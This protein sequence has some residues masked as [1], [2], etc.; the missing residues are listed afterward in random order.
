MIRFAN[1]GSD[2]EHI[3]E[4]FKK[5]Y[6]Q[7]SDFSSFNLDNMADVMTSAK[8]ASSKGY[9]GEEALK[10]SY[11]IKDTSRNPLYNQ[12]KMYAEVYRMFGWMNSVDSALEF[13]FTI[14]GAHVALSGQ[15][16][17]SIVELCLF[18]IYFPNQIIDVRFTN[19]GK[20]YVS[21][22]KYFNALDD[23]LHRDE[24]IIGALNLENSDDKQEFTESVEQIKKL[25]SDTNSKKAIVNKMNELSENLGI[26]CTTM[27]NYTRI[28]IA[29][30]KYTGWAEEV[31]LNVYGKKTKF[32][33]I[34]QYGKEVRERISLLKYTT[35]SELEQLNEQQINAVCKIGFLTLLKMANFSVEEDLTT[36]TKE[37]DIVNAIFNTTDI[38]FNPFQSY[39]RENIL[40]YFPEGN[41]E[42][43]G[44]IRKE[45]TVEELQE[46][47]AVL[48]NE[49]KIRSQDASSC[50]NNKTAKLIIELLQKHENNEKFVIDKLKTNI[51]MM[52]QT[53]FYPLVADLFEIIFNLNARTPQAGVNN[54]RFDVIIPDENFSI[55]VE[56][57]SPTEEI[58]L[59]VKAV[60]QA[61][62]NK[63]I[64][65][66]RKNYITDKSISSIAVGFNIPNKRSD[67][68]LLI[69]DIKQAFDINISI[70]SIEQLLNAAIN[71][72]RNE[73]KYNIEDFK[74]VY[75]VIRFED[76]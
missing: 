32:L 24:I 30:L 66:S 3:A 12:A 13:K 42:T 76:L 38:F 63:I 62:E 72:L 44:K 58:M 51:L 40:K 74:H 34:T 26:S 16:I 65:L 1:P 2:I 25:R 29:A 41:L 52:K 54:E 71:C 57:K 15:S 46:I 7:L 56:V 69:E 61:L 22:M 64:L 67:V 55:P 48:R 9:V 8:M 28:L 39:S 33:K 6:A 73:K 27:R 49:K 43:D 18:G 68:Y 17:K 59:S 31:N 21:I 23:V 37:A 70:T 35:L 36:L 19:R 5:I 45:F 10:R 11:A 47:E 14:L 60:R 20:P 50:K 53:H 75:G 4:I